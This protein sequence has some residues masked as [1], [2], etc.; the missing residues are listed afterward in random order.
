MTHRKK[1]GFGC[2]ELNPAQG[3]KTWE[4]SLGFTEAPYVLW[5]N[6]NIN[7]LKE[8]PWW[9]SKKIQVLP[10]LLTRTLQNWVKNV[11]EIVFE[12]EPSPKNFLSAKKT[13]KNSTG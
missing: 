1:S 2:F 4:L 7:Y 6:P 11:N 3:L 8:K 12:R 9:H 5:P 10:Y 13:C